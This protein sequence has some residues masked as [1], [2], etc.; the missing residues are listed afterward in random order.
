V[1]SDERQEPEAEIG[2][3]EEGAEDGE[4]K[5]F[6]WYQRELYKRFDW[7]RHRQFNKGYLERARLR[8]PGENARTTPPP[9]ELVAWRGLWIAEAF[10][11]SMLEDLA[12]ALQALEPRKRAGFASRDLKRAIETLRG[13]PSIRVGGHSWIPLGTV[14]GWMTPLRGEPPAGVKR[15]T[16][17]LH[18]PLPS[19]FVLVATFEFDEETLAA[20]HRLLET[21][22]VTELHDRDGQL[23]PQ[24][25]K[26]REI[27][28]LRFNRK[29]EL[30]RWMAHDL[31]LSGVFA[32][33][34]ADGG[35]YPSTEWWTTRIARPLATESGVDPDDYVGAIRSFSRIPGQWA[36]SKLGGQRFDYADSDEP[37]VSD[38][39]ISYALIVAGR[40]DELF[41]GDDLKSHG[42]EHDRLR[43][44]FNAIQIDVSSITATWALDRL[45]RVYETQIADIRSD[46]LKLRQGSIDRRL[47][48]LEKIEDRRI[49]LVGDMNPFLR[50]VV[51]GREAI[52]ANAR[53]YSGITLDLNPDFA[54]LVKHKPPP[55][56]EWIS[57][58][59]DDLVTRAERLLEREATLRELAETVSTT[60][61]ARLSGRLQQRVLFLTWALLVAAVVTIVVAI[62]YH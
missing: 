36:S 42:G 40:E 28:L 20:P 30:A 47:G 12:E 55:D 50:D 38:R 26:R 43:G 60:L 25:R 6:R 58:L 45:H 3:D 21:E 46:L 11:L 41:P 57:V 18:V 13:A 52:E 56:S 32:A 37:N 24:F 5:P 27:R 9:G 49:S 23:S 7:Y 35:R 16:L 15:V 53:L 22:W 48:R 59:C 33:S 39:D 4:E 29:Q 51:R 61:N 31:H 44:A 10:T 17:D 8:D 2:G 1:E 54:E 34:R 14:G 62:H 19:V